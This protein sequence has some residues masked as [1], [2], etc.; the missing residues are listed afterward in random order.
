M[1]LLKTLVGL[2]WKLPPVVRPIVVEIV[3]AIVT[4]PEDERAERA[5]RAL[6]EA[7]RVAAFDELMKRR[8]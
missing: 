8:K 7:S 5:R 3:K 4:A 2:F 6:E 1:G